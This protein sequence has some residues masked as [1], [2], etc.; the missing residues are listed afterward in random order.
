M[1][2]C[3]GR[4]RPDHRERG[5]KPLLIVNPSA[6]G[7]R[8][9][10]TFAALRPIVERVLGSVDV[11]PTRAR[12][13]GIALA[14]AAAEEGRELVI[15]LGGDGTLHEVANGVLGAGDGRGAG[16]VKT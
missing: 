6:G 1:A 5:L 10:R 9:G 13:H 12:G 2:P 3:D 15:S 4:W 7:G 16:D 8:A 14:R 11:E